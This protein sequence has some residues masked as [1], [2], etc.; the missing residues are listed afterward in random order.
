[1]ASMG[2]D[3]EIK[4][5]AADREEEEPQPKVVSRAL[6]IKRWETHE[7]PFRGFNSPPG[8]F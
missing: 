2:Q 8:R 5:E 7:E 6:Q 3:R 4:L 1:M